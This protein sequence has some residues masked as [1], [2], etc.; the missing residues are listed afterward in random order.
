[1]PNGFGTVP[2]ELRNAATKIG[3]V[4]GKVVGAVW[5]PPSGDYGHPGVQQGWSAFIEEMKKN[6]EALKDKADGHGHGLVTAS[7]SYVE[8]EAQAGSLLSKVGEALPGE[9]TG[10][11]LTG[12]AVGIAPSISSRLNPSLASDAP[13][14]GRMA[15]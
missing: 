10:T 11:G 8:T 3:D 2:E 12:G 13:P 4:V 9:G 14:P 1:M 15:F 7:K 5:Q 6:I